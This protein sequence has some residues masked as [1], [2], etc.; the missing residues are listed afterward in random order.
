MIESDGTISLRISCGVIDAPDGAGSVVMRR[1]ILRADYDCDPWPRARALRRTAG[2][3]EWTIEHGGKVG[4]PWVFTARS[5]LRLRLR[6]AGSMQSTE[7]ILAARLPC[8]RA[9][10]IAPGVDVPVTALAPEAA[11]GRLGRMLAALVSGA[12]DTGVGIQ[13]AAGAVRHGLGWP[14]AGSP[15]GDG[16]DFLPGTLDP[17]LD[18]LTAALWADRHAVDA[19]RCGNGWPVDAAETFD[20]SY[21][22]ARG[23]YRASSLPAFALAVLHEQRTRPKAWPSTDQE[24]LDTTIERDMLVSHDLGIDFWSSPQPVDRQHERRVTAPL[25]AAAVL[26]GDR[27]AGVD[28]LSCA[29]DAALEW[30]S[31]ECFGLL[32][33]ARS[34]PGHGSPAFG[35]ATWWAL[36]TLRLGSFVDRADVIAQA[37]RIAAM[38]SGFWQR[39]RP[40]NQL[41]DLANSLLAWNPDPYKIGIPTTD[42]VAQTM[43][44]FIGAYALARAG[45]TRPAIEFS[46]RALIDRPRFLRSSSRSILTRFGRVPK[47]VGV[48]RGIWDSAGYAEGPAA[49]EVTSAAGGWDYF[50]WVGLGLGLWLDGGRQDRWLD[51]AYRVPVPGA[52][53]TPERTQAALAARISGSGLGKEQ[54]GLVLAW[55]RA[56]SA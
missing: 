55:L 7:A 34:D 10:A 9:L 8:T 44:G 41:V 17:R 33:S 3:N 40:A 43:E 20:G 16:L 18:L 54:T 24:L 27:L 5:A 47:F 15:G 1:V 50:P 23:W 25:E 11:V 38:P 30:T 42:E 37:A 13:S 46:A 12:V 48:A 6:P 32:D 35:R 36:D 39:A 28:L 49:R 51:A 4:A 14:Q 45:F 53:V 2:A 26:W 31:N 21:S 56:R 22:G 52:G 19:L 29:G